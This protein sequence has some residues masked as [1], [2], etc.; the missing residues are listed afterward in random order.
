LF[1]VLL[2]LCIQRREPNPFT[3]RMG[4]CPP[5]REI[6][7]RRSLSRP[8]PNYLSALMIWRNRPQTMKK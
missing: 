4:L 8:I 2:A 6:V 3:A 1:V 5:D 7:A